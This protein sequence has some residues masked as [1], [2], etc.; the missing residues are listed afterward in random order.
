M[1]RNSK[2]NSQPLVL[3][4]D[5]P[6]ALLLLPPKTPLLQPRSKQPTWLLLKRKPRMTRSFRKRSAR[7]LR[8]SRKLLMLPRQR[9]MPKRRRPKSRTARL[10]RSRLRPQLNRRRLR[11]RRDKPMPPPR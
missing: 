2:A 1:L 5:L 8:R 9:L 4:L 10:R 6:D 3:V 11:T 7:P